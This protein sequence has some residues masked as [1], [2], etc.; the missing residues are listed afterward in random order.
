MLSGTSTIIEHMFEVR[1]CFLGVP[2]VYTPAKEPAVVLLPIALEA[3][4]AGWPSAAQ[5]YYA[6]DIDLNEHLIRD[7]AATFVVR[8]VGESM[9]EAGISHGDEL[10]VDRSLEAQHG[11]VVIAVVDGELTVKRLDLHG[12]G[13]VLKA[14]GPG[15]P[16]IYLAELSELRIWGVV[17]RCL[18]HV[19]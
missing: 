14:E 4:V 11:D 10:I 16:D 9:V 6:G 5:D 2:Q 7:R 12:P 15:Y 17:T 3:V 8:V 1:D 18:H 19:R 13:V